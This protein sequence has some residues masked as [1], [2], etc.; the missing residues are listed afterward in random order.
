MREACL[1]K[2]KRMKNDVQRGKKRTNIILSI[3]R[4]E[5]RMV[6][7]YAKMICYNSTWLL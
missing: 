5:R 4:K 3:F 2:M 6:L 1:Q 7:A